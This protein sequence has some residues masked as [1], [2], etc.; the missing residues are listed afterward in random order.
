MIEFTVAV[1]IL[2]GAFGIWCLGFVL[3]HNTGAENQKIV[4]ANEAVRKHVAYWAPDGKN[5]HVL[6]WFSDEAKQDL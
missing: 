6:R 5:G 3:G 4:D 2:V 1:C